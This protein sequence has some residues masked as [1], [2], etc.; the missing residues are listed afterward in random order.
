MLNI[1]IR[2]Q[3][4]FSNKTFG[5]RGLF[6]KTMNTVYYTHCPDSWHYFILF[7]LYVS[8]II[9]ASIFMF[10]IS[11]LSVAVTVCQNLTLNF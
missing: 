10:L 4:I 3:K 8:I 1:L 11:R 9:S 5:N 7:K 6:G 2:L